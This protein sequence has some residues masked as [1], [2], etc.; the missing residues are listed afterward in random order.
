[1]NLVTFHS[2]SIINSSV[3]N[4]KLYIENNTFK[5]YF[6]SINN[7]LKKYNIDDNLIL[8]IDKEL[9]FIGFLF[10]LI[11]N[12]NRLEQIKDIK[13]EIF[14]KFKSLGI[15]ASFINKIL[16]ECEKEF[17]NNIIMNEND[18]DIELDNILN[19]IDK[20]VSS[21]NTKLSKKV[22][23]YFINVFS[24]YIK[25][26]SLKSDRVILINNLFKTLLE[27][28]NLTTKIKGRKKKVKPLS[29]SD[30]KGEFSITLNTYSSLIKTNILDWVM[31][32]Y[33]DD[34]NKLLI[35]MD[36]LRNELFKGYEIDVSKLILKDYSLKYGSESM[37]YVEDKKS[38]EYERL[39]SEFSFDKVININ[40]LLDHINNYKLS[41]VNSFTD[42]DNNNVIKKID[43]FK[44]EDPLMKNINSIINNNLLSNRDKQI[45]IENLCLD[46]DLNW[47]SKELKNSVDARSV[48]LHDIHKKLDISLL[49]IIKPYIKSDYLKLYKLYKDAKFDKLV[50]NN[51]YQNKFKGLLV[52]MILGNKNVISTSFKLI[53]DLITKSN[54]NMEINKTE[55][56]F[57]LGNNL[58]KFAHYKLSKL[59]NQIE[60]SQ[61]D[62][63]LDLIKILED[64]L[65]FINKEKI[66][67]LF[68][69]VSE[70]DKFEI[71]DTILRII[72]DNTEILSSELKTINNNKEVLI[73]INED[74][75][76]KLNISCI[77]VTQLPMLIKP[78]EP[79]ETGKYLPYI[80][81]EI[82]HIY[83]TFDTIVKNKYDIRD[84]VKNQYALVDS[85]N[86]LNNTPFSINED[87][88]NFITEEWY[89]DNSS[90]FKGQNKLLIFNENDSEE[91]INNKK[92][93]NSKY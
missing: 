32:N 81:G 17:N 54:D 41:L 1:M 52:I 36:V 74:Y 70:K 15:N 49:Y 5:N 6:N 19:E 33:K 51:K 89:N 91:D 84:Q 67:E 38:K 73:S 9:Y 23:N 45:G 16:L 22:L 76:K 57:K 4:D 64:L 66:V 55:I 10:S 72:L 63:D 21:K 71:G 59:L 44:I 25:I 85:I 80:N 39:L 68:N 78:N 29:G 40:K 53:V 48:I 65:K 7:I 56:I 26:D 14:N 3:N 35:N 12:D 8:N 42:D 90:F 82:S 60:Q 79:D 92:S 31:K 24:I 62:K 30:Y 20:I 46:Y 34:I 18:K 86:Y 50:N 37:K 43:K 27:D 75:I 69:N 93:H 88:L 13:K 87:I 61:L 47:F 11:K 28:Q 77:N 58:F 83:N 2:S